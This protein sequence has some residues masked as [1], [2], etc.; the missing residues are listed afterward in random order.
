MKILRATET[1]DIVQLMEYKDDFTE[2]TGRDR[3]AVI[4]FLM[5][6]ISNPEIGVWIGREKGKIVG[7]VFALIGVLPPLI[8]S[9]E[10]YYLH[11]SCG[12]KM[13]MEALIEIEKWAKEA[14][15]LEI[16]ALCDKVKCR[17]FSRYG[18]KELEK[19]TIVKTL[20][21]D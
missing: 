4:Q 20:S 10:I 6:Y 19:K 13:H 2:A 1:K 3:V 12:I 11:S 17:A 21:N 8:E 15:A 5:Q 9:A 18:F 16:R 7:W 14:G